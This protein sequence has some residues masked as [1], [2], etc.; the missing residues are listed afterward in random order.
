MDY[1]RNLMGLVEK[2]LRDRGIEQRARVTLRQVS[3][4][5]W[6]SSRSV[7]TRPQ[8]NVCFTNWASKR[9]APLPLPL[10]MASAGQSNAANF[11]HDMQLVHDAGKLVIIG[12]VVFFIVAR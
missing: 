2:G 11:K 9:S 10:A 8:S 6:L 1:F 3:T 4:P 12:Y 7:T 5:S